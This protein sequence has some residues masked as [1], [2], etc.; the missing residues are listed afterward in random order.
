M[1]LITYV[2]NCMYLDTCNTLLGLKAEF[3]INYKFRKLGPNSRTTSE[4][5]K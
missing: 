4:H 3:V 5:Y 2:N 1:Y